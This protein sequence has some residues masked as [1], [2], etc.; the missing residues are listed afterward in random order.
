MEEVMLQTLRA[1]AWQRAKGELQSYLETYYP[2]Y[3]G[4]GKMIDNGFDDA[5]KRID[6]FIA[7]FE[8]NI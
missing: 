2:E 8:D 5:Q 3:D 6:E 7:D 4:N 1:M